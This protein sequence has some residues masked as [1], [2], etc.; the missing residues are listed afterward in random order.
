MGVDSEPQIYNDFDGCP[1]TPST[2][3]QSGFLEGGRRVHSPVPLPFLV[4]V[5]VPPRA[6]PPSFLAT[7]CLLTTCLRTAAHSLFTSAPFASMMPLFLLKYIHTAPPR[8]MPV[9]INL[10]PFTSHPPCFS[11]SRNATLTLQIAHTRTTALFDSSRGALTFQCKIVGSKA[12]RRRR[13]LM[14]RGWLA[15]RA[16]SLVASK[17]VQLMD[18][19]CGSNLHV[20]SCAAFEAGVEVVVATLFLM[21][22][23]ADLVAVESGIEGTSC[24]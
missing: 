12:A 16:K 13:V 1:A 22:F 3:A 10:F 23:A 19:G 18:L 11:A 20:K 15:S 14:W 5:A 24:V 8:S 21:A 4:L 9:P 7:P 6:P 2:Q 17:V